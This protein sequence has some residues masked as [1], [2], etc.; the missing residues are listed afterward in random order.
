MRRY[1]N[2]VLFIWPLTF[3]CTVILSWFATK[4]INNAILDNMTDSKSRYLNVYYNY[5]NAFQPGFNSVHDGFKDLV[6]IDASVLTDGSSH[7]RA[8]IARLLDTVINC[9][10]ASIGLDLLFPSSIEVSKEE[11][12]L[13]AQAVLRAKD[14][15]VV[16]VGNY[17]LDSALVHSFF[18]LS[19]GVEYGTVNGQS[20]YGFEMSDRVNDST[21]I[22]KFVVKLARKGGCLA[23]EE[24]LKD[25][26]VD[27]RSRDCARQIIWNHELITKARLEGKVV[28]IGEFKDSR[29]YVNLPFR[30]DGESRMAG[31]SIL[32]YQLF[33][34]MGP[35]RMIHR[36]SQSTSFW[37][38]LIAI[39]I[40]S[41]V[42]VIFSILENDWISMNPPRNF[43]LKLLGLIVKMLVLFLAGWGWIAVCCG[44]ITYHHVM[45]D[46][47]VFFI[48]EVLI[49]DFVCKVC[50][51]YYNY[52]YG[53][54]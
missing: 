30:I 10:P 28:L 1:C 11:D 12:M 39:L 54:K 31:S 38:N 4:F 22:E 29:D 25:G 6:I 45:I 40:L 49:L 46:A 37:V 43:A 2:K 35:G 13:L 50:T 27:Y 41:F 15:L 53:E 52:R 9:N 44:I 24:D 42:F 48:A 8:A 17:K 23:P 5:H 21:T 36:A 26:I 20:F 51:M 32:A 14:K 33:S 47:L 18:T 3:I 34:I 16:A 19:T 7:E